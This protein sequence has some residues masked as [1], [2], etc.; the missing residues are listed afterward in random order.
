MRTWCF[1]I[2]LIKINHT[3]TSFAVHLLPI[4]TLMAV[5]WSLTDRKPA[6]SEVTGELCPKGRTDMESFQ[7]LIEHMRNWPTSAQL[8]LYA[9]LPAGRHIQNG[10]PRWLANLDLVK[11][12]VQG[13]QGV[14]QWAQWHI[15]ISWPLS[16]AVLETWTLMLFSLHLDVFSMLSMDAE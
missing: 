7:N 6:R 11:E 13:L 4:P 15:S 10:F 1:N 3:G 16:G 5:E 14:P 2:S 9:T 12:L 8:Q